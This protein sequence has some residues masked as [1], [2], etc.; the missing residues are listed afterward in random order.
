MIFRSLSRS[1]IR[2][3]PGTSA[4][5][6]W[7]RD[8]AGGDTGDGARTSFGRPRKRVTL[9]GVRPTL[10]SKIVS[11]E[12]QQKGNGSNVTSSRKTSTERRGDQHRP[13]YRVPVDTSHPRSGRRGHV[14]ELV[15]ME[16][17]TPPAG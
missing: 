15:C 16:V 8:D 6:G 13:P 4:D 10:A 17:K 3:R 9:H 5:V 14:A 12:R 1:L 7:R 11:D 2:H